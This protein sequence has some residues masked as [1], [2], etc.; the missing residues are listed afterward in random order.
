MVS[1]TKIIYNGDVKKFYSRFVTLIIVIILI[2]PNYFNNC[3]NIAVKFNIST[4][5]VFYRTSEVLPPPLIKKLVI[6][7]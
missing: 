3:F 5:P 6:V 7:A 1:I 2:T 4:I